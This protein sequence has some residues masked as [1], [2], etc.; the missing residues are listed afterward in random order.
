M[1]Q[2]WQRFLQTLLF[3][4]GI[5]FHHQRAGLVLQACSPLL[6]LLMFFAMISQYFQYQKY[7]NLLYCINHKKKVLFNYFLN[8]IVH[9]A[10]ELRGCQ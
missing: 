7:Y 8:E 2:I 5:Y 1:M 9:D 6:A 4:R 10:L 3:C